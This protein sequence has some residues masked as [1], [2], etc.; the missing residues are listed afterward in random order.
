MN[1]LRNSRVFYI[2]GA[3]IM[4]G[5]V[6]LALVLQSQDPT[7]AVPDLDP[8]PTGEVS[9][10]PTATP[11]GR[12]F[13]APGDI[14]RTEFRDYRAVVSTSKGDFTIELFGDDA[15]A[16]VNSFVFLAQEG[17]YD[18]LTFHRVV[19]D[20]VAQ[21]GDPTDSTTDLRDGPGYTLPEEPN[22]RRNTAGT[23]SMHK[24]GATESEFGS[25]WF[26]NLK[27]NP[28]L[29]FDSGNPRLYYPFGEVTD[30]LDVALSIELGDTVES[31][32]I[33]F[34]EKDGVTE[35]D[36]FEEPEQVIDADANTYTAT[37]ATAKG[38]IVVNLFADE[39]PNTVNNFVFLAQQGF[40]DN[41]TFHRV[42]ATSI[43][44]AQAGDPTGT[45]GDGFDGPGYL[46]EEEPNERSNTA[47]T[48]SMAKVGGATAFGS[49]WFINVVDNGVLDFDNEQGDKFYPFA[50]IVEGL[51]VAEQLEQGDAITSIAITETPR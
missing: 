39:S 24:M 7:A 27:D 26:I 45:Q 23:I 51:E 22:E 37:I 49:Q 28:S 29:D 14:A 2:V 44:V 12:T 16:T 9:P 47:G 1:L 50:E 17:F 20:F 48:I 31:I 3:L 42:V 18:G 38:E 6:G 4:V 10:T 36:Q 11:D 19:E 40:F 33:E 25:Q 13:A 21:T 30:G 15:P 34:S 32:V 43:T 35:P 5:G 8:T 41:T 46:V